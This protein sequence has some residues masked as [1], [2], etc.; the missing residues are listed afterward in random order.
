MPDGAPCESGAR[1]MRGGGVAVAEPWTRIF[2]DA[3]VHVHPN[4]SG[5]G[6][7]DAAATHVRRQLRAAG[8]E[9]ARSA[10]GVLMLAEVAGVDWYAAQARRAASDPAGARVGSWRLRSAPGEGNGLIAEGDGE[11]PLLIVP[12]RQVVS[13]ERLEI[14]LLN[15]LD[16]YP[17]DRPAEAI[18]ADTRDDASLRVLAWGVGKWLGRRGRII[19]RLIARGQHDPDLFIGDNGGRP[20]CWGEPGQFRHARALG[21]RVLRGTDA[22]NLPFEERRVGSFGSL[23]QAPVPRDNPV[24]TL[25]QLLR[26]HAQPVTAYGQLQANARFLRNQLGLRSRRF[27]REGCP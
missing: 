3:H 5:A 6:V 12:G 13:L 8:Q 10:V 22:L 9:Q 20:V 27:A 16:P 26:D 17:D 21:M 14:L 19:D 2:V 25:R 4:H 1:V 15:R 7:L 18:L 24:E 23:I 11:P